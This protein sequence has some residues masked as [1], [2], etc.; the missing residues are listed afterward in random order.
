MKYIAMIFAL[1]LCGCGVPNITNSKSVELKDF[2]SLI[3]EATSQNAPQESHSIEPS[4]NDSIAFYDTPQ[5]K[6][7]NLLLAYQKEHF[8][9]NATLERLA[10][11]K[12]QKDFVK[13]YQIAQRNI[14]LYTL[15]GY[16]TA[17]SSERIAYADFVKSID[18]FFAEQGR[19][20][21]DL[22]KYFFTFIENYE[23]LYVCIGPSCG[24]ETEVVNLQSMFA[25]LKT[26]D[27][28]SRLTQIFQYGRN[29][30]MGYRMI[31]SA[32][33]GLYLWDDNKLKGNNLFATKPTQKQLDD[34]KS[35]FYI[36]IAPKAFGAFIK[37]WAEV[38]LNRLYYAKNALALAVQDNIKDIDNYA[39]C[40][41]SEYLDSKSTKACKNA[42]K[43][44][45]T[46]IAIGL[47]YSKNFRAFF[48]DG[49]M[50]VM[51]VVVSDTDE[52][53]IITNSD[54]KSVVCVALKE[55]LKE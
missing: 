37:F 38:Y 12:E 14:L 28:Q 18:D 21:D 13:Y 5:V 11:T 7:L 24:H 42:I 31:K 27:N 51:A 52:N 4:D 32:E 25:N 8:T 49:Q 19:L 43:Q 35:A 45:I 10:Q 46:Q 23:N 55:A 9:F 6:I 20:I 54:N 3:K 33:E 39:V 16:Y 48:S 34:F 36:Y 1:F 47:K 29:G 26:P 17:E 2:E 53:R 30:Y 15:V 41:I 22:G 50:C 40:D 44:A